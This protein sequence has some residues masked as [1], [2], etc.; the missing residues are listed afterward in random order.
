MANYPLR[1][2]EY[3][4][5]LTDQPCPK[6][7]SRYLAGQMSLRLSMSKVLRNFEQIG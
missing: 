4:A 6:L 5:K 7:G 1:T 2:L 3:A